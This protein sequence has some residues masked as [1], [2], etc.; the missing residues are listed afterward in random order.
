MTYTQNV[1]KEKPAKQQTSKAHEIPV[2]KREE[3]L[4]DLKKAVKAKPSTL[5]HLPLPPLPPEHLF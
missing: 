3:F 2:P 5:R 1:D 4:R